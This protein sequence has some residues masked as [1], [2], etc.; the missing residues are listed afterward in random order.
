MLPLSGVVNPRYMS[1]GTITNLLAI[2]DDEIEKIN[3][4]ENDE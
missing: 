1:C 3:G 2:M 4:N